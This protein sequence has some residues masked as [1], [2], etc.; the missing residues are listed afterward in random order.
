MKDSRFGVCLFNVSPFFDL[1]FSLYVVAWTV[2]TSL[3]SIKEI[4]TIV[5]FSRHTPRRIQFDRTV[6]SCMR[7]L[8]AKRPTMISSSSVFTVSSYLDDFRGVRQVISYSC[9]VT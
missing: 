1:T 5:L 7:C 6:Q 3:C 8:Q 9:D 2:R 4:S